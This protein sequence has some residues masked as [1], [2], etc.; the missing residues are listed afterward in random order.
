MTVLEQTKIPMRR[1]T[2]RRDLHQW[3]ARQSED[4]NVFRS[5]MRALF[6]LTPTTNCARWPVQR[7]HAPDGLWGSPEPRH[8]PRSVWLHPERGGAGWGANVLDVRW[9]REIVGCRRTSR[10]GEHAWGGISWSYIFGHLAV[11]QH[12]HYGILHHVSC[13]E[14]SF[15]THQRCGWNF[16]NRRSVRYTVLLPESPAY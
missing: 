11:V 15:P 9:Y 4:L 1:K 2:A 7:A 3:R 12:S 13:V 10:I 14:C 5:Y 8:A 16:S 6:L